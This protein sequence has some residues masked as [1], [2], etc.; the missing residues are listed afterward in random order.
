[1]LVARKLFRVVSGIHRRGMADLPEVTRAK[2]SPRVG[3]GQWGMSR[4]DYGKPWFVNAKGDLGPV[5]FQQPFTYGRFTVKGEL[6]EG[7]EEVWPLVGLADVQGG[8]QRF[9]PTNKTL[10]HLTAA[11]G[12]EIFRGDR[13]PVDLRG[14]LL[15]A[16]PVGRLIRRTKIEIHEGVTRLRNA[17]DKS[18]FIRSTDPNFRPVN[19]V[20]APDG[21]L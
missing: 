8:P 5:H 21:T 9:R 14:D 4:D 2:A 17:Y 3:G 6:A 7:F 1:M 10:N 16:E 13:L 20:T 19:L 15:F 12:G 11:C 18:E